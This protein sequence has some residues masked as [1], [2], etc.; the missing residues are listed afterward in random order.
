MQGPFPRVSGYQIRHRI[1]G[2]P[3]CD[4]FAAMDDF[5]GQ[6]RAIKFLKREAEAEMLNTQLFLREARIGSALTH[7]HLVRF[8][9]T[10]TERAG[11]RHIVMEYLQGIPM[12]QAMQ[13]R[14]L[15]VNVTMRFAVQLADALTYMHQRGYIHGD[16]KPEN[17]HLISHHQLKLLD[18]GFSHRP[19]DN[20]RIVDGDYVL[21]TANYIAPEMCR[22]PSVDDFP[23]DVFA[24]GSLLYEMLTGELPY[25][26][27]STEMTMIRHRD[28]PAAQ[29]AQMVG[30]WPRSLTTLVDRMTHHDL[31]Q[32][33]TMAEVHDRLLLMTHTL[34]G[35][36]A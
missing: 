9:L 14:L 2:G 25:E 23:G 35:Q 10:D 27:G 22:Q 30:S 12:R 28:E 8:I 20:A 34:N 5:T 24:F 31:R 36:A 16:V 29:L 4:V 21:G 3:L 6:Q 33:P 11:S 18:F 32:R 17:I 19:G 7:P 15:P 13:P 26:E 1:G